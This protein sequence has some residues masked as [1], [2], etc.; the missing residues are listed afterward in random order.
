M[1][2]VKTDPQAKAIYI[3]LSDL[4]VQYTTELDEDRYIDYA[5]D[6]TPVGIDLLNVTDGVNTDDLPRQEEIERFLRG[7]GIP[8][9]A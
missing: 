1:L 3:T 2:N 4:P 5:L 9:F 7:M 6:G 8:L